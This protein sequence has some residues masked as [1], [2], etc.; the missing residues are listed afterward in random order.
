MKFLKAFCAYM[1]GVAAGIRA[2]L[3][4][5]SAVV[6]L[7]A[8]LSMIFVKDIEPAQLASMA[9]WAIVLSLAGLLCPP[10]STWEKWYYMIRRESE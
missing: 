8:L 1:E 6:G 3:C 2:W 7:V 10:A 4:G 9:R 5:A